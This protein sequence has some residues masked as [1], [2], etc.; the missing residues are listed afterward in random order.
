MFAQLPAAPV[1]D[2][3]I[4]YYAPQAAAPPFDHIFFRGSE[5]LAASENRLMRFRVSTG[6]TSK[7]DGSRL[8]PFKS[9]KQL[10][11]TPDGA[12]MIGCTSATTEG[13][14]GAMLHRW[15]VPTPWRSDG[16]THFGFTTPGHFC[17]ITAMAFASSSNR[18]IS[19]DSSGTIFVWSYESSPTLSSPGFSVDVEEPSPSHLNGAGFDSANMPPTTLDEPSGSDEFLRL[20]ATDVR[21]GAG[22]EY[23]EAVALISDASLPDLSEYER[24]ALYAAFQDELAVMES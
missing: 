2:Q 5:L 18:F 16:G 21:I 23:E 13:D 20:L 10:A 4:A 8:M 9:P 19:A 12:A 17:D 24:R 14:G 11:L 15:R 22:L 7:P 1:V 3:M 6:S